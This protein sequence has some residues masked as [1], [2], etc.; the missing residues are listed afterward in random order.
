MKVI[1]PVSLSLILAVLFTVLFRKRNLLSYMRRGDGGLRGRPLPS[2]P[3]WM[4]AP[5]TFMLPRRASD[6]LAQVPSSLLP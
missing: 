1:F 4:N 5:P 2:S 3:G 6:S